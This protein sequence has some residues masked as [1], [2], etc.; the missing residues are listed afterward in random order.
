MYFRKNFHYF[1]FLILKIF[2]EFL[3]YYFG[4]IFVKFAGKFECI[5][6]KYGRKCEI[7]VKKIVVKFR[8]DLGKISGKSC[9]PGKQRYFFVAV[10][11]IISE[12][13]SENFVS[14]GVHKN[15]KIKIPDFFQ[16]FFFSLP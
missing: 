2:L 15:G 14:T 8:E 12:D 10:S 3:K 11:E 1:Y 13:F 4:S 9:T 7:I 5:F 16:T 6:G